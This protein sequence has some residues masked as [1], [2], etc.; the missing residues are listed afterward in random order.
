[1]SLISNG[2]STNLISFSHIHTV[3]YYNIGYSPTSLG[4]TRIGLGDPN[5]NSFYFRH[6]QLSDTPTPCFHMFKVLNEPFAHEHCHGRNVTLD[7]IEDHE[8]MLNEPLV[9]E[10]SKNNGF[11]FSKT[12][13]LMPHF[14]NNLL[15]Y[16][17]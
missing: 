10:K 11:L 16:L 13:N 7:E 5:N 9:N 3:K 14:V 12:N 8:Y 17:N 4:Y 1:M 2:Y 15:K 6:C